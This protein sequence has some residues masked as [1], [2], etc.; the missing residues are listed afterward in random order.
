MRPRTRMR[1]PGHAAGAR[2]G[3]HLVDVADRR[4]EL[5]LGLPV[6]ARLHALADRALDERDRRPR[7]LVDELGRDRAVLAEHVHAGVGLGV[8]GAAHDAVGAAEQVVHLRAERLLQARAHLR[9]PGAGLAGAEDDLDP[10]LRRRAPE[11]LRHLLR[12]VLGVGRRAREQRAG[13]RGRRCAGSA[14]C[15]PRRRPGSAVRP[16]A[17][18]RAR[19][20]R[21]RGTC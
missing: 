12:E 8:A 6:Q 19:R 9:Q 3:V 7:L 18:A 21:R 20:A 5:R 2:I 14:P 16:C 13:G 1:R 10:E 11:H 4:A 15:R 17:R